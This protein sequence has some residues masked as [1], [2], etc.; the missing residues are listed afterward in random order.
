MT[1]PTKPPAATN[2]AVANRELRARRSKSSYRLPRRR[3]DS[4]RAGALLST[5]FVD[6]A[7]LAGALRH[8]S[9]Q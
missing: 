5:S 1:P 6:L 9:H 2:R 7:A 3:A 4:R 8:V